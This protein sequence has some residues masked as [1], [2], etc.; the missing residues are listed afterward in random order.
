MLRDELFVRRLSLPRVDTG[1]QAS[2]KSILVP[3]NKVRAIVV[4]IPDEAVK[5]IYFTKVRI[6]T[7]EGRMIILTGGWSESVFS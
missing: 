6:D 7:N 1:L 4:F 3:D 2:L 5:Y